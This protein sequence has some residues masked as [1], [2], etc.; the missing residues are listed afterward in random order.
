MGWERS[1]PGAGQRARLTARARP[2]QVGAT[3]ASARKIKGLKN[4]DAVLA[5]AA[6]AAGL[7]VEP[8]R[9]LSNDSDGDGEEWRLSSM[10]K[11]ADVKGFGCV[12][13]CDGCRMRGITDDEVDD[14]AEGRRGA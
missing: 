3:D 4:E 9:V 2:P 14:Y 1:G 13:Y 5:V 8:A 11:K 7:A 12:R 10:P 6:A